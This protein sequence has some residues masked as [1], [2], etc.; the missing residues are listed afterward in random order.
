M[1]KN[2]VSGDENIKGVTGIAKAEG[3]ITLKIKI[4]NIMSNFSFFII[5]SNAFKEDLLL[6][7][8][9]IQRFKLSQ[10]ENL[11]IT[12]KGEI[13]KDMKVNL[14]QLQDSNELSNNIQTILKKNENVFAKT[15][16][17]IGIVKGYEAT[18]KLIENK[19]ISKKPYRCSFQDKI[20]I[21]N[22]I[23]ELLKVGLIEESCSPYAAPITMIYKKEEGRKSRLCIDFRLD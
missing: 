3:V 15:K 10:N 1:L 6:G 16:F 22:Q 7:L 2:I 12:Q 4:G 5:K 20:E 13:I 14:N 17:D 19:Y 9:L 18:I 11:K 21:E 23:K 8:D